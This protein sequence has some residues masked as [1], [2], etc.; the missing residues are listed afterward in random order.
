MFLQWHIWFGYFFWLVCMILNQSP[1]YYYLATAV[2][3]AIEEVLI[4][5][6]PLMFWALDAP[7]KAGVTLISEYFF[8][9]ALRWIVVLLFE[10]QMLID[11]FRL[12]VTFVKASLGQ[13]R[14]L[15]RFNVIQGRN[16][17]GTFASTSTS[18]DINRRPGR[19]RKEK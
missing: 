4:A 1:W 8:I 14:R 5:T 19:P 18:S 6:G 12:A 13:V 9:I 15:G 7:Y 3:F 10:F 11:I 17:D 2:V 16:A